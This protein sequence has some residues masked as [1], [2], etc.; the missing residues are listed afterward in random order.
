MNKQKRRPDTWFKRRRYGYGWTPITWQG[1]TA[2]GLFL[3][4]VIA[5]IFFLKDT[6][7]NT[8]TQDVILYLAFVLLAILTLVVVSYKK[9]P[10]PKW[11]WGKKSDDE[12]DVDF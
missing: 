8:V 9:G 5:G 4:V 1:W 11:R 3:C 12:S 10:K 2:T 7:R 6:P